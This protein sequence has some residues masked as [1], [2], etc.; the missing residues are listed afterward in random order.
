M[1]FKQPKNF[2]IPALFH[3]NKFVTNFLEKTETFGSSR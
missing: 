1:F 2:L 3:E